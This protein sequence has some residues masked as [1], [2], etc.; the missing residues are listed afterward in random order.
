MTEAEFIGLYMAL[1]G[2]HEPLARSVF[3]YVDLKQQMVLAKLAEE[4]SGVLFWK[5]LLPA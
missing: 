1:T 2:C 5:Q 3:M 4:E